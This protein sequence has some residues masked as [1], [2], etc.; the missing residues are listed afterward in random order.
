MASFEPDAVQPV[1]EPLTVVPAEPSEISV[2]LPP[3]PS[4][5]GFHFGW[6][7]LWALA[8]VF[9]SQV[10]LGTTL[11]L[12]TFLIAGLEL[13]ATGLFQKPD[14]MQRFFGEAM[15]LQS[16]KLLLTL[17]SQLCN[18]MLACGF[19]WIAYRGRFRRKLAIRG[20]H[21]LHVLL[22]V[23]LIIPQ[24]ILLGT[25]HG[26][27]KPWVPNLQLLE[28]AGEMI[29]TLPWPA[30]VIGISILPGIGEEIFCRG[31]LGR[32]LVARHGLWLGIPAAAF[33]FGA[34]HIEPAQAAYAMVMGIGLQI[35]YLSAR[36]L[37]AAM[38]LHAGNNGLA[39][40]SSLV[41][42]QMEF[43]R[44]LDGENEMV[45]WP[46]ALAALAATAALLVLCWTSRIRWL[47]RNGS[48]WTPGYATAEMPGPEVEAV[49]TLTLPPLWAVT[50]AIAACLVF[51]GVF[52]W[53]V[54]G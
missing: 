14:G 21:P 41:L 43:A 6:A 49:P 30:L 53:Q 26:L 38:L 7:C 8:F 18:V 39:L 20:V 24:Y 13:Y 9:I 3:E 22:V 12:L 34:I 4:P 52:A 15:N 27:V 5:P 29:K 33:F 51:V 19:A 44:R 48:E 17:G 47:Q 1:D 42:S 46:I 35:V 16:S 32:G 28:S 54:A 36:S 2:T 23:L 37:T 31:F 10:Q 40:L 11:G 25:I 45:P 50:L